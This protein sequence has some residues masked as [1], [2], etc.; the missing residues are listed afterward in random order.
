MISYL[1]SLVQFSPAAGRAGRCRQKSLCV[2]SSRRVLAKQPAVL[3]TSPRVLRAFSLRG[4]RLGWPEVCARSPRV[5]RAFSLHD[6]RPG[7]PEA[8]CPL[9]GH[10]A[11]FPSVASGPGSQR[12]GALS[13]GTPRLFPPRPQRAPP[14]GSQIGIGACLPGGRGWLLWGSVCPFPLP[15]LPTSS[16]DGASLL[17]SFSVPLFCEPPAV[18]S[19]RL[20]FLSLSHSLKKSPSDCSQGLLAGPYPKDCRRLLSVPPPLAG[21]GCGR[22]GVL[23]CWELLLGT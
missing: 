9:H 8:W 15:L 5:R 2:G 19:G 4:E 13:T 6:E 10:A 18:C 22:L 16:G 12:F 23:F 17:W 14:V 7:Q 21:G 1:G 11:P 20:I 3:G